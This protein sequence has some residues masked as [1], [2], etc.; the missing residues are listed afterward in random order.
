MSQA[1]PARTRICAD[2][3]GFPV[4]AIDTGMRHRDGTRKTFPVTCPTCQGTGRAPAP[5]LVRAAR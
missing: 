3:D 2:C 1:A 4:V 5:A